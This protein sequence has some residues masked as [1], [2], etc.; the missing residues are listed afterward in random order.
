LAVPEV[1]VP[2]GRRIVRLVGPEGESVGTVLPLS[3]GRTVLVGTPQGF[4]EAVFASAPNPLALEWV[5]QLLEPVVSQQ[6]GAAALVVDLGADPPMVRRFDGTRS[7]I[8]TS[9]QGG[10]VP[11]A[12]VPGGSGPGPHPGS[13]AL[14]GGGLAATVVGV[15]VAALAHGDGVAFQDGVDS[16]PVYEVAVGKY[17]AALAPYEAARTQE[18]VGVG[19]AV[20]GGLVAAVGGV[21]FVIPHA[22]KPKASAEA[23]DR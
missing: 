6:G 15:I 12:R 1:R 4:K 5:G 18:R 8:L 14:F 11:T 17:D 9:G 3:A 23:A 16:E 19:L 2:A 13:V 7:L 20:G 22:M 10:R 21:T